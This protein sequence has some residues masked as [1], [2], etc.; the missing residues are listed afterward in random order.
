MAENEEGKDFQSYKKLCQFW[1]VLQLVEN[2]D[3]YNRFLDTLKVNRQ[4]EIIIRTMDNIN[5]QFTRNDRITLCN[6]ELTGYTA[7]H[8]AV[9]R[10]NEI[11]KVL[12]LSPGI[13]FTIKTQNGL[14]AL[15]E[16]FD[17]YYYQYECR[18]DTSYSVM[19][20]HIDLILSAHVE[21][22]VFDNSCNK[23]GISHFH[24]ACMV[25]HVNAVEFFLC[26]GVSANEVAV[27]NFSSLLGY[28]PL[29]FAVACCAPETVEILL[30]HGAKV[31]KKNFKGLT[32]IHLLLDKRI[33][34]DSKRIMEML[35]RNIVNS[36]SRLK[37]DIDNLSLFYINC[38]LQ[39]RQVLEEFLTEIENV[40]RFEDM[41]S[42]LAAHFDTKV[43]KYLLQH[44]ADIKFKYVNGLTPL[45]IC[46]ERYTVQD[47]HLILSSNPTW[48]DLVVS[49]NKTR[50]SDIVCAMKD[51][52]MLDDFLKDVESCQLLRLPNDSPLWSGYTLLHLAVNL[53]ISESTADCAQRKCMARVEVCLKYGA[54]VTVQDARGWTAL[55][56][57]YRLQRVN[58]VQL[59]LEKYTQII[60]VIDEDNLSHL[61]IACAFDYF[62]LVEKL[63]LNDEVDVN[64]R[65][66][67]SFEHRN[68]QMP[69]F[70]VSVGSTP[71]HAAA[72]SG[73]PELVRILLEHGANVNAKDL[74]GVTPLHRT[75]AFKEPEKIGQI[76]LSSPNIEEY[77]FKGLNYLHFAA[78]FG[79]SENDIDRFIGLGADVDSII[80]FS[81][82]TEA[83][84][85][86]H[87]VSV[88]REG[89]NLTEPFT[90]MSNFNKLR[91]IDI[92]IR[93]NRREVVQVLL[94]YGVDIISARPDGWTLVHRALRGCL[95]D[96]LI[97]SM[98]KRDA[99]LQQHIQQETGITM[100]HIACKE[101]DIDQ[102]KCYLKNESNVNAQVKLDSPIWPGYTAMHVL[103]LQAYERNSQKQV[104]Q[105]IMK[106]LL[107]SGAD[108][109]LINS[110][111]NM[112]F[113]DTFTYNVC[114]Q[115]P[116]IKPLP[117]NMKDF[118]AYQFQQN[119]TDTEYT[120]RFRTA[121][122]ESNLADMKK[123]LKCDV[124]VNQPFNFYSTTFP[125]WTPLHLVLQHNSRV[126]SDRRVEAI[127]LLFRHGANVHATD[128]Y[129]NSL[130]HAVTKCA[131]PRIQLFEKILSI[132]TSINAKNIFGE[133]P[134][135]MLLSSRNFEYAEVKF[136]LKHNCHANLYDPIREEGYL[137]YLFGNNHPIRKIVKHP[138]IAKIDDFGRNAIHNIVSWKWSFT[139]SYYQIIPML[140]ERGCHIDHQDKL[141]R[142]PLHLAVKFSNYKAVIDLLGAGA[143]INVTD[144]E[145]D[146]PFSQIFSLSKYFEW[147]QYEF[148]FS[149]MYIPIAMHIFK[150]KITGLYISELNLNVLEKLLKKCSHDEVKIERIN[151]ELAK[152]KHVKIDSTSV[153]PY[154]FFSETGAI[155]AFPFMSPSEQQAINTFVTSMKKR[156][157]TELGYLLKIRHRKA[158]KRLSLIMPATVGLD[159][160]LKCVLPEKCSRH[161][162]QFLSNTEIENVIASVNLIFIT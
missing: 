101:S 30:R 27:G 89:N 97:L 81:I 24:I 123:F 103:A 69:N 46:L 99:I 152:M 39:N 15:H 22:N 151:D 29:H 41:K 47:L 94:K 136:F 28:T 50:L 16:A 37:L 155:A 10:K 75:L 149:E 9:G 158:L 1:G 134:F 11:V 142:T 131:S 14:T 122:I 20:K 68:S 2:D 77:T 19:N 133:E 154:D 70:H 91:P 124:N 140:M 23:N 111:N 119:P 125:G 92:A 80:D 12:L 73:S 43:A 54:D 90:F 112:P 144:A 53:S 138:S 59:L 82:E 66:K 13:D 159:I 34:I 100:L 120:S 121:C 160:L 118:D 148:S 67:S 18:W 127:D 145:G 61:Y 63:L 150:M 98:I 38:A 161:I 4:L 153:C 58:N 52:I 110:K 113:N 117:S 129:G 26:R 8:L 106:L 71:L 6:P 128:L 49:D 79:S 48:R 137:K 42:A 32:P 55:H 3:V 83:E 141:G 74:N 31:Y 105:S 7:L 84:D 87:C 96:D 156:D 88:N 62:P 132:G 86:L 104:L 108:L 85:D 93:R 114:A 126:H 60:N 65:I 139:K 25:N 36:K 44:E 78:E 56:L 95:C 146:S 116:F 64:I 109:T 5:Y 51:S 76:L 147:H 102:V 162:L 157:F 57:A 107:A 143:D 21:Y 72:A 35:L 115:W 17:V 33:S 40:D 135:G 45:D 130:F